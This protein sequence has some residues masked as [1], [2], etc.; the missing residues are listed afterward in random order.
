MNRVSF[1][2]RFL[3]AGGT[4]SDGFAALIIQKRVEHHIANSDF[5]AS[6]QCLDVGP[7][8]G[9]TALQNPRIMADMLDKV[10]IKLVSGIFNL[11]TSGSTGAE[12]V[13]AVVDKH[14]VALKSHQSCQRSS[15]AS[16][17]QLESLDVAVQP[18]SYSVDKASTVWQQL[19]ALSSSVDGRKAPPDVLA[20]FVLSKIGKSLIKK[21]A[22]FVQDHAKRDILDTELTK[23][24]EQIL[25][26]PL[27][28]SQGMLTD[29]V[30]PVLRRIGHRVV[31]SDSEHGR[32]R[33]AATLL[34]FEDWATKAAGKLC[35]TWLSTVMF[36]E[37]HDLPIISESGKEVVALMEEFARF[38]CQYSRK[39]S[40]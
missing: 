38:Y 29:E 32:A 34:K 3:R 16:Q 14:F 37:K 20:A 30:Q 7:E 9:V 24:D 11:K 15:T 28:V 2:L 39:T 18:H 25:V 36:Q 10:L 22:T 1:A 26:W 12:E 27:V 4:P 8:H 35:D 13:E 17:K 23:L 40:P 33:L 19:N 31:D 6:I 5:L 21:L